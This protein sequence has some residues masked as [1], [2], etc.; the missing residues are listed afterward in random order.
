MRGEGDVEGKG[1]DKGSALDS[2]QGS[3]LEWCSNGPTNTTARGD[4]GRVEVRVK[5]RVK[6]KVMVKVKVKVNVLGRERVRG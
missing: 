2:L 6:V 3:R 4:W 1:E 5:G